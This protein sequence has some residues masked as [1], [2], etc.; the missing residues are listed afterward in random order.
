AVRTLQEVPALKLEEIYKHA[1]AETYLEWHISV[2]KNAPDDIGK[3]VDLIDKG[4]RYE[5]ANPFLLHR[6]LEYL[7]KDGRESEEANKAIAKFDAEHTKRAAEEA[8]KAAEQAEKD[9]KALVRSDAEKGG[10]ATSKFLLGMVAYRKGNIAQAETLFDLAYQ[11]QPNFPILC[12]NFA[13]ML[14]EKK[15]ATD[16]EIERA[17]KLVN[18]AIERNSVEPSFRDTRGTIYM[19]QKKWKE[20]IGD[21]E[22]VLTHTP[23]FRG[24]RNIHAR[25]SFIYQ[26]IGQP[27]LAEAHRELAKK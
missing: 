24:I 25:L 16:K 2:A 21:L 20:A 22:F 11:T 9:H 13:W 7:A 14:T 1:I 17:L 19:R 12:N 3:Q 10:S 4:L 18:I 6:L 26:E 23:E 5:P 15:D 8:K 27:E